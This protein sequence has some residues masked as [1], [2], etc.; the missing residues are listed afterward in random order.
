MII[1]I[2]PGRTG[3]FA[4]LEESGLTIKPM[5]DNPVGIRALLGGSQTKHVFLEKASTHPRD[6]RVGAFNYGHH[7]GVLEGI[8]VALHVPYTLV[9]PVV[10]AKVMHAGTDSGVDTKKRS[11]QAFM[12]LFPNVTMTFGKATKP[13]LGAVEAALI[14]EYG[15]RQL[16][17]VFHE[18]QEST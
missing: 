7:N 12:R 11:V 5:P 8:L 18:T 17:I 10:W 16:G 14:A 15:R 9:P 13:H 3:G 6:G 2:D 1:G 4:L